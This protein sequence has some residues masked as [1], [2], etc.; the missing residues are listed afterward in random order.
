[1]TR[2]SLLTVLAVLALMRSGTLADI[3]HAAPPLQATPTLPPTV[4][5]P[6]DPPPP[7]FE[8][9]QAADATFFGRVVETQVNGAEGGRLEVTFHVTETWTT[10]SV[11]ERTVVDVPRAVWECGRRPDIG[12]SWM[13]Y[14]RHGANGRL[15]IGHCDRSHIADRRGDA[16]ANNG[17]GTGCD[18]VREFRL[19]FLP[20]EVQVGEAF[21]VQ[22]RTR[23]LSL[24]E[25]TVRSDP[26][27]SAVV[28]PPCPMPCREWRHQFGMR[29]IVAGRVAISVSAFG[30]DMQCH[31]SNRVWNWTYPTTSAA[32]VIRPAGPPYGVWL[33][34][35]VRWSPREANGGEA[36][37]L[38]L[39]AVRNWR[40]RW[41]SR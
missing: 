9:L 14:A 7:P 6:C 20:P 39:E 3:A 19:A 5:P 16:D 23:S 11:G 17:L 26:P 27:E 32:I 2:A 38:P 34:F 10:D 8:A 1:M 22:L 40:Q 37:G 30:E 18:P 36:V 31:R 28:D 13:V 35:A 41:G 12:Q 21:T 15:A 25:F 4:C 29:A 33:P 24:T